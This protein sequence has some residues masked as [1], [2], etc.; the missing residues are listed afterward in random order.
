AGER[1][2]AFVGGNDRTAKARMKSRREDEEPN[3]GPDQCGEEAFALME[4]TQAFTPDN[5]LHAP[6]QAD[7][8]HGA[9]SAARGGP[10]VPAVSLAKAAR[11]YLAF[12]SAR[13][14]SPN[15]AP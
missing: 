11:I 6:S 4:K 13:T 8:N 5:A 12:V 2:V 15:P 1:T 10:P 14:S 7:R 3:Q 9:A